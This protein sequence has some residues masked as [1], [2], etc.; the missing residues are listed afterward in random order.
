MYG[1]LIHVIGSRH[2]LSALQMVIHPRCE[3]TRYKL[4]ALEIESGLLELKYLKEVAVVGLP[5]LEWGECVPAA[6]AGPGPGPQRRRAG[7][8]T[9]TLTLTR[10]VCIR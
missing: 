10:H 1:C 7:A 5:D 8:R 9:R 3:H 6:G 2:Q 4:S